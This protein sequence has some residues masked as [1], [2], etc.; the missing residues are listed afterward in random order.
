MVDVVERTIE[1]QKE[2]SRCIAAPVSRGSDQEGRVKVYNSGGECGRASKSKRD[3][4]GY[5]TACGEAR[6]SE[7]TITGA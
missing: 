4:S 5:V 7:T 2:T 1:I 6:V 3:A